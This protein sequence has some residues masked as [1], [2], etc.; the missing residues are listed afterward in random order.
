MSEAHFCPWLNRDLCISH[1]EPLEKIVLV[2]FCFLNHEVL[3]FHHW[4]V[5]CL[6][7]TFPDLGVWVQ[8]NLLNAQLGELLFANLGKQCVSFSLLQHNP[9]SL[10]DRNSNH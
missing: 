8:A 9:C 3:L 2:Y 4:N 5:H 6:N 10:A 7:S 1:L